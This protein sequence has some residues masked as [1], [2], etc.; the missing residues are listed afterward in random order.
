MSKLQIHQFPARA[1]NYGVLVHDSE[2]EAT[3]SIDAPDAEAVLAA[4]NEKGWELTHILTT[5]HH[6]D[7]TAGNEVLK[8]MTGC[9]IVGPAKEARGIPGIDIK[10]NEGDAIEIGNIEGKVIETPGHTR[11]H[12]SYSFPDDAVVFVGDT[13]FSVG[14]GKLLEGDAKTM[15]AS[16]SKLAALPPKTAL[17]CGHEYTRA[18]ARFALTIEPENEALKARAAEVDALAEKGEPALPTTIAQELATNPFLRPASPAIQ[19]RLGM[20]GRPLAEIFGEIRKRK[21]KF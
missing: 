21:D 18:N 3:A 20:E 8:R 1:D 9:T 10:V 15:W 6:H 7:H 17:Y 11:G 19:K 12:V 4:L 2:T 13:L 16:L 5:H 14:C